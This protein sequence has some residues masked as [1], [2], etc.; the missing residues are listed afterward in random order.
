MFRKIVSKE[1]YPTEKT[2]SPE[3]VAKVVVQCIAGEMQS[4]SGEVLWIHKTV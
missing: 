3:D 1:Q 4:T 2:L